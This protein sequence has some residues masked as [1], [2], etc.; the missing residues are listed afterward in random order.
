M[1]FHDFQAERGLPP[2]IETRQVNVRAV[3]LHLRRIETCRTETAAAAVAAT[4]AFCAGKLKST[5]ADK[6][7]ARLRAAK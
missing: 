3:F 7:I 1:K 4:Q 6:V 2:A 5:S